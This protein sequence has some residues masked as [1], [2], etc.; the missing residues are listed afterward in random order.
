M[1][2]M[3]NKTRNSLPVLF[4]LQVIP[5]IGHVISL[6]GL[7]HINYRNK[8]NRLENIISQVIRISIVSDFMTW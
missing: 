5:I 3:R 4:K 2:I 7:V 1:T 8:N 6:V